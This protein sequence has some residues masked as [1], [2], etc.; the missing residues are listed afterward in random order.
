M[1][2]GTSRDGDQPSYVVRQ[3]INSQLSIV[4]NEISSVDGE[5]ESL[6][7]LREN[8]VLERKELL[9]QLKTVSHVSHNLRNQGIGKDVGAKVDY[10]GS[11]D[12]TNAMK[13][14]MKSVFGIESFRLC[15]EA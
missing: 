13:A 11:F 5:I 7:Q 4:E 9:N 10:T 6:Q 8:L 2:Q 3:H 15:Q 14:R 12:W 1:I